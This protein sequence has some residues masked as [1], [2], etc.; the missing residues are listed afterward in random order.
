MLG[1]GGIYFENTGE[2]LTEFRFRNLEVHPVEGMYILS[3]VCKSCV[4]NY[5][6]RDRDRPTS[7]DIENRERGGLEKYRQC[8]R[9]RETET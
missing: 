7:R 6:Y 2:F 4:S 5:R 9:Q 1:A 8:E 3:K